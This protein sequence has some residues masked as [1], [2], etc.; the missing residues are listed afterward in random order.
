VDLSDTFVTEFADRLSRPGAT[1]DL[2][3]QPALA[4]FIH[5][6]EE[7]NYSFDKSERAWPTKL[8]DWVRHLRRRPFFGEKGIYLWGSVGRGKT[9]MMDTLLDSLHGSHWR[10]V[11]FHRFMLEIHERLLALRN[12]SDPLR[13][14]G[15]EIAGK[16]RVLGFD[17]F[18]VSDIGDAMIL[19]GLLHALVEQGMTLIFTSNT[20]PSSLYQG[21]LQR[22]RFL[23]AIQLI[24]THTRVIHLGGVRDYRLEAL[25]SA[26]TYHAP[27]NAQAQAQMETTFHQISPGGT[28][29]PGAV[30]IN[31]RKIELLA[32]GDGI[33]WFTFETLCVGPRSKADYVEISRACHT[34]LISE[35][36]YLDAEHDDAARRFVE[37]IDE[38]YDRRVNVIASAATSPDALYRGE[39]MARGFARTASRLHEFQS[40]DYLSSAHR[41]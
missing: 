12:Q 5:L 18:Y 2:D 17:E 27:H 6:A 32:L 7:L 22:E 8:S 13:R 34:L 38:L 16:T 26:P 36:P 35:V 19:S 1:P 37:L 10:R 20:P 24:E 15:T 33:M 9:V 41:P 39:R 28:L 40:T 31:D 30:T 3:Q 11:H 4:A 25:S 23:P 21:G 14:I 29:A